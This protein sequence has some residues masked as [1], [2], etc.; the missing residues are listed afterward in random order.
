MCYHDE[1][2]LISSKV[3]NIHFLCF[4]WEQIIAKQ[5]Q[6]KTKKTKTFKNL[7]K[8]GGRV[9]NPTYSNQLHVREIYS[10]ISRA[11]PKNVPRDPRLKKKWTELSGPRCAWPK[12]PW[13][14]T[15]Q[16][17]NWQPVVIGT[18]GNLQL[19]RCHW[20]TPNQSELRSQRAQIITKM[21]E[22]VDFS[23][24]LKLI[25]A[26]IYVKRGKHTNFSTPNN[27]NALILHSKRMQLVIHE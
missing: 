11:F 7:L 27:I 25:L 20:F 1:K 8:Q 21:A 13:N 12:C 14:R 26:K 9:P 6:Q 24:Q 4:K 5:Q 19:Q 22:E 17:I 3:P 23:L 15:Q 10:L 18:T 16:S 2:R